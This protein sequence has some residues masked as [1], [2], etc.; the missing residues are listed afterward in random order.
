MDVTCTHLTG[1]DSNSYMN[2]MH[3]AEALPLRRSHRNGPGFQG[4]LG[5][6]QFAKFTFPNAVAGE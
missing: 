1:L 2:C 3:L 5:Q 6:R 4:F